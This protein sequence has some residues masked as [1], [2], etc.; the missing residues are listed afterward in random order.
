VSDIYDA[1][2]IGA[3]PAGLTAALY[4]SRAGLQTLVIEREVIGGE[5]MNRDLIENWPG[6]PDGILGP[7]LSSGMTAQVMNYG[8][9]FQ[10]VEVEGL[11]TQGDKKVVRTGM[12]DFTGRTVI[13]A[14]GASPRKLGITGEDEFANSGVFYCATCDGPGFAGKVVAVAGGGDSGLTEGLFL[15]QLVSRVIIIEALPELTATKILRDRAT[16]NPKMEIRCGTKIEAI[17]GSGTVESVSLIDIKTGK[18]SNLPVEGVLVHIGLD[19]NTGYLQG[20]LPLDDRGQVVV[21]ENMETEVPG[22]FAAGDIRHN[23]AMQ[24][25]TAVGDGATAALS[26]NRYLKMK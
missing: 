23:S 4:T 21:N 24:V 25:S 12:G 7:E 20:F 14:G 6:Q 11:E 9:K 1:I 10:L 13:I 19:P 2:I 3:G 16:E 17:T 15:S 18:I 8:V 26:L 5:L 22:V